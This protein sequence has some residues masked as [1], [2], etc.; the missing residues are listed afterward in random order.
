LASLLGGLSHRFIDQAT[1]LVAA[2]LKACNYLGPFMA[3]WAGG[4]WKNWTICGPAAP[5]AA[6]GRAISPK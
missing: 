5:E 3:N 2:R 4:D 6:L 1:T